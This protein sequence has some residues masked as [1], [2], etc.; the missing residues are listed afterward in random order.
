MTTTTTIAGSG[1]HRNLT[2]DDVD[3]RE[4]HL[5]FEREILKSDEGDSRLNDW[6]FGARAPFKRF[7]LC[8][9]TSENTHHR[10]GGE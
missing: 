6:N 5:H 10:I 7:E 9:I 4:P 8:G 2:S 1:N 3:T